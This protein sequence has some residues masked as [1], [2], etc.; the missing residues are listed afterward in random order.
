MLPD[1]YNEIY[2]WFKH[3]RIIFYSLRIAL[4]LIFFTIIIKLFQ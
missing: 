3:H 2:A 4:I 1:D